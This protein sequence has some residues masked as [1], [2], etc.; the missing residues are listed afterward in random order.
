MIVD[1]FLVWMQTAPLEGRCRAIAALARA[2]LV[3]DIGD[4]DR[5]A[6]EATLT[7]L[8]D[9]PEPEIMRVIADIMAPSRL[10]PRHL[11]LAL[12]DGPPDIAAI[13]LEQS[14]LLIEAELIDFLAEG[15]APTQVAIA[16]RAWLS[17]GLSAAIAE[18]GDIKAC[19][20][21]AGN[22]TASIPVSS[23]LRIADRFGGDADVREAMLARGHLPI[24]VRHVLL[25]QASAALAD[26]AADRDWV[27]EARAVNAAAEA[28]DKITVQMAAT[29]RAEELPA[30]VEHLRATG[31]LTTVLLMRAATLGDIR[32]L[33]VALAR[34][35]GQPCRRIEG[36]LADGRDGA[37]RALFAKAG[38][39][40]RVAP[41]FL[42]ALAV[43][44]AWND[45]GDA[46][47]GWPAGDCH[48][49]AMGVVERLLTSSGST[50]LGVDDDLV[51][52]VRRFAGDAA[53]DA[54]RALIADLMQRPLLLLGAPDPIDVESEPLLL[55]A[56]F[57]EAADGTMVLAD[58][59]DIAPAGTD[60]AWLAEI[61]Q[62]AIGQIRIPS[63]EIRPV[64]AG[65]GDAVR[66]A[67]AVEADW[68]EAEW[69]PEIKVEGGLFP[70]ERGVTFPVYAQARAA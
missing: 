5:V 32:F 28:R 58:Y 48:H 52:L 61:G 26:L 57:T 65:A 19:E 49:F 16:L 39:P 4:A 66:V 60:D 10:A 7:V 63:D 36:L 42:A 23:L 40:A 33:Q 18:V 2:Y 53:R 34:L 29:A 55:A 67:V 1:Q 11:I 27:S 9:D 47:T 14:P 21:L 3:S 68:I 37:C 69:Y 8:L 38:L 30:F 43:H 59:D 6:L 64:D 22:P 50:G 35:S 12:A 41:A 31:Q 70:E 20:A 51:V 62:A 25:T 15:S 45:Y 46:G 54:A 17:P 44:R 13:V 24:E 56:D